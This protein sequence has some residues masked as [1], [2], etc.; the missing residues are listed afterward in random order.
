MIGQ[1]TQRGNSVRLSLALLIINCSSQRCGGRWAVPIAVLCRNGGFPGV[2][3]GWSRWKGW[4][5]WWCSNVPR[6]VGVV[7]V[8]VNGFRQKGS[9]W[10]VTRVSPQ[11][12]RPI[13]ALYRETNNVVTEPHVTV[14]LVVLFPSAVFI[15]CVKQ[16]RSSSDVDVF[17]IRQ[18]AVC[19]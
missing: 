8:N 17:E 14:V 3:V 6:R 10:A 15:S 7:N 13:G 9:D 1:P 11:Q 12:G 5:K 4:Q 19:P 16:P 2:S 18:E